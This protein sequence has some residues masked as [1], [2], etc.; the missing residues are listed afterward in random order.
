MPVTTMPQLSGRCFPGPTAPCRPA[1]AGVFR[2]LGLLAGP[3]VCA[4]AVAAL[5][6]ADTATARQLLELLATDVPGRGE[7]GGP[8]PSA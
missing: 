7:R 1:A 8:L 3:D 4:P 5:I 6:A 2:S